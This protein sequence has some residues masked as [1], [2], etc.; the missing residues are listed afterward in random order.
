MHLT[1]IALIVPGMFLIPWASPAS[2]RP[3]IWKLT[4]FAAIFTLICW[5]GID[6]LSYLATDGLVGESPMRIIYAVLTLTDVP[7][8]ALILGSFLNWIS[9]RKSWP[10]PDDLVMP[11]APLQPE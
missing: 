2:R 8:L 7:L 10:I 9:F 5:L 11:P 4:G 1:W 6:L 3:L